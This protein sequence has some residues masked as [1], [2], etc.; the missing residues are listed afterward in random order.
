MRSSLSKIY[1]TV[2]VILLFR[3]I[4]WQLWNRT[5]ETVLRRAEGVSK[6]MPASRLAADGRQREPQEVFVPQTRPSETGSSIGEGGQINWPFLIAVSVEA[7]FATAA[8]SMFII[9]NRY[10]TPSKRSNSIGF[11]V[12]TFLS[13]QYIRKKIIIQKLQEI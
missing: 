2:F 13:Y 4:C 3:T 9:S 11:L 6:G 5:F 8:S 1:E 7:P 12:L 10:C